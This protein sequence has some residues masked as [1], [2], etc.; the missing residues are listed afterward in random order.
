LQLEFAAL[1]IFMKSGFVNIFGRPNAG[2]STL[3]NSLIGEKLAIVSPKVQTTRHRIKGIIT[4][5]DH[6][7]IFSDTPGII[8]PRY[9]LHEKMMQAVKSSL[10]D[11]DVAL[12]IVD[13]NDDWET[14]DQIFSSLKLKVPAIVVVN[15]M[16]TATPEKIKEAIS[17]FNDKS[18]AKKIVAISALSPS[19]RKIINT[20]LEFLPEG[21]KFY[22][23]D[24]M[25]DLSTRFFVAELVR[26]K[27]YELFEEEIPYHTAV[28]VQEFKEKKTLVKIRAEIIVQRETQKA[29]ILG[30]GGRMIK[31]LGTTSR[32]EIEKF[33][34]QKVFLELFVKVR[35]KWRER[36]DYLR[37]FGY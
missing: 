34:K 22:D 16:D 6:Q 28:I 37:E 15:K 4:E 32:E 31:R 29:I 33:L 11:A 19:K 36:E 12:L 24:E 10:E 5:K 8:E 3:L 26:E 27:I 23:E 9:K 2:K 35:E 21:Q 20:I 18:Y 30:E 25:T 14:C 7:I 17:F 13:I 1:S